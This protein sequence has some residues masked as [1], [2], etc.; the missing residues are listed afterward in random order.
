[1]DTVRFT[2]KK[3]ALS[4][5]DGH[6]H[7][8]ENKVFPSFGMLSIDFLGMVMQLDANMS[9]YRNPKTNEYTSSD[10]IYMRNCAVSAST[11]N[12][13]PGMFTNDSHSFYDDVELNHI[14]TAQGKGGGLLYFTRT[15]FEQQL[16]ID[17]SRI[18]LLAIN[19]IGGGIYAIQDT[20]TSVDIT[21]SQADYSNSFS[22]EHTVFNN[23]GPSI[24]ISS[25]TIWS[26]SLTHL[27]FDSIYI[28]F[29]K[30]TFESSVRIDSLVGKQPNNKSLAS[31]EFKSSYINCRVTIGKSLSKLNVSF[32]DCTFGP[33]ANLDE[34]TV[35]DISFFNC[36]RIPPNVD[37][38]IT[39]NAKQASIRFDHTDASS[40][41]FTY[42]ENNELKFAAGQNGDYISNSY[43]TLLEKFN[44]ES[45]FDSYRRLDLELR[46]YQ[47]KNGGIFDKLFY[48]INR[49][50]WNFGYAKNYILYWTLGF[51]LLFFLLNILAWSRI[52][53]IYSFNDISLQPGVPMNFRHKIQRFA[54]IFFYT[55]FIFFSV[56]IDL[57]KLKFTSMRWV[58]YF[59]LQYLVGL[60]C[61]FFI[62]NALIKI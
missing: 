4:T 55:S 26:V 59:F 25:S 43:H 36:G 22:I 34:L 33:K 27:Q 51:L 37:L 54:L 46:T 14:S 3:A 28:N 23:D 13:P 52:Q 58:A 19:K 35:D 40:A 49:I 41:A 8:I 30:D 6:T 48:F 12:F 11:G 2:K 20:F 39:A 5:Y 45:K 15:F 56:R 32:E 18:R 7:T 50:W 16:Q 38:S 10:M 57:D 9:I 29:T 62:F 47:A 1:M 31:I 60:I 42:N 24:S 21:N 44:R 61:V 17:S 53:S